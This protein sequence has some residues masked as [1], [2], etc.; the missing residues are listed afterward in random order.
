M[1]IAA[2]SSCGGSQKVSTA[3][4]ALSPRDSLISRLSRNIE[5]GK[6]MFGHHDDTAYGYTWTYEEGRS[7]VRDA[8][9][10]YPAMMSWDLGRMELGDSLNLDGVPFDFIRKQ[11][12]AQDARGGANT[13]SWHL[14]SPGEHFNAWNVSDST[15]VHRMVTDSVTNA[16][17]RDQLK[18]LA[19]WFNSL[20]KPSG[21]KV[22]VVFRPWH[23]HTGGWF[24][25]GAP[26]CS[27]EDYVGL[28][29]EMR[30]VFDQEGVDNIVWAYS[31]DRISSEEQYMERYPGDEYVDIMGVDVY[32]FDGSN[33]TDTYLNDGGKALGIMAK[34]AKEHGK[35]PAFTETGL[36]TVDQ[37]NWYTANLLT[38]LKQTPVSYVVVWR[39]ANPNMKANHFYVPYKGHPAFDNFR[40]FASSPE[41]LLVE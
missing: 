3:Q 17:Y 6:V 39:N 40:G 38:L 24:W 33:G 21:E 16:Q 30:A 37:D 18:I 35:I 41:I 13:L 25:W 12:I 4:T 15:L 8:T 7:D 10:K 32:Q 29:K 27:V 11:I 36:E 23:E 2:L 28:W 26:H 20:K 5:E 34:L 1:A 14:Y 31:P 22:A 9:G 19:S